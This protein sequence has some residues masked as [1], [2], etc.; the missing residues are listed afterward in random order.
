[1]TVQLDYSKE[2]KSLALP[3]DIKDKGEGYQLE[4]GLEGVDNLKIGLSTEQLKH[5]GSVIKDI[6]ER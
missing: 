2:Y 6:L 5:L 4:L 1:M 3:V